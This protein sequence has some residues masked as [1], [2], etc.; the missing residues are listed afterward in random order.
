MDE[1]R[2]AED[3]LSPEEQYLLGRIRFLE[4]V[5]AVT[6]TTLDRCG[7]AWRPVRIQERRGPLGRGLD[8]TQDAGFLATPHLTIFGATLLLPYVGFGAGLGGTPEQLG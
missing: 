8:R 1:Q 5:L 7:S 3:A 2:P 4:T 6:L